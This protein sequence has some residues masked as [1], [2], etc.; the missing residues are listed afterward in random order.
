M[1]RCMR[2][3]EIDIKRTQAPSTS[4]VFFGDLHEFI[5]VRLWRYK[6]E[7]SV[8]SYHNRSAAAEARGHI[9]DQIAWLSICSPHWLEETLVQI[10]KVAKELLPNFTANDKAQLLWSGFKTILRIIF[11][12][13]L[14]CVLELAID[15][16]ID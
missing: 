2:R 11:I 10:Q 5:S 16:V 15:C 6:C 14:P 8:E 13:I 9:S 3:H 1:P 7:R 4:F 12:E